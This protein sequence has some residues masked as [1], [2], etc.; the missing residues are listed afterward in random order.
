MLR[1]EHQ[2]NEQ[3]LQNINDDMMRDYVQLIFDF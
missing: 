2:E 1:K 3:N